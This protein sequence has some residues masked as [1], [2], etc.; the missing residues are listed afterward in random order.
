MHQHVWQ[1]YVVPPPSVQVSH[2]HHLYTVQRLQGILTLRS[3]YVGLERPGF[4]D[5]VNIVV[6]FSAETWRM[7]TARKG[8]DGS[9]QL[10]RVW[11]PERS[12]I[13]LVAI[14]SSYSLLLCKLHFPQRDTLS[15]EPTATIGNSG[16]ER[17]SE[18][19]IDRF[20]ASFLVPPSAQ[21]SYGQH[22]NELR[23]KIH[24]GMDATVGTEGWWRTNQWYVAY[25]D[26]VWTW[27]S[28]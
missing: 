23:Q 13:P 21:W 6:G 24:W 11:R 3:W 2:L 15:A 20:F 19:R 4:H 22:T 18:R 1:I 26:R 9:D 14:P 16:K 12:R 27:I 10:H 25:V 28:W 7:T 8:L 17:L 5:I